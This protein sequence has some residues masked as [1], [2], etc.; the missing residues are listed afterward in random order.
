MAL[1]EKNRLKGESL[2]G[3]LCNV[4]LGLFV[5]FGSS[6][7]SVSVDAPSSPG[8]GVQDDSDFRTEIQSQ[9]VEDQGRGARAACGLVISMNVTVGGVPEIS[10]CVRRIDHQG[11]LS[12]P[13]IGEVAIQGKTLEQLERMLATAYNDYY[14]D[15]V[16]S[17]SFVFKGGDAVS[18]PW[19]YVT[20]VGCVGRSGPVAIPP[21]QN[22]RVSGAIR[23]AGG[24]SPSARDS[25]IRVSRTLEN[26]SHREFK[27]NMQKIGTAGYK[28]SDLLLASG[29]IIYV[30]EAHF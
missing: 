6:C 21:T 30:P 1:A 2:A 23:D 7:Q 16:V 27:V 3:L 5:L 4:V 29:D 17:C 24:F 26:G 8:T 13:Y 12:L 11:L 9:P 20:V 10:E 19:G 18:S 25:A 22:L 15:P 14:V 28:G